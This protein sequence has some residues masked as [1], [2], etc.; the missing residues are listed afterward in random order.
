LVSIGGLNPDVNKTLSSI[1]ASIM[2]KK[3]SRLFLKFYDSQEA[4]STF[5]VVFGILESID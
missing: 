3:K 4:I 2:E 5:K 1:A